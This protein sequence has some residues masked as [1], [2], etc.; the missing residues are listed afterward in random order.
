VQQRAFQ[1][2]RHNYVK[3]IHFLLVTVMES[4]DDHLPK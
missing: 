3:T 2:L 4:G 1:R